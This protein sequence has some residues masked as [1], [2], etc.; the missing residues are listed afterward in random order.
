MQLLPPNCQQTVSRIQWTSPSVSQ[1]VSQNCFDIC[2][3]KEAQ[4]LQKTIT[5]Q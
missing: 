1:S 5:R 2:V 3:C 4:L